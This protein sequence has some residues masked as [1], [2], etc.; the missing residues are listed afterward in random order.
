[1]ADY[2]IRALDASTVMRTTVK[3]VRA[4]RR[5]RAG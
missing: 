2:A 3:P 4:S 1:M 5:A